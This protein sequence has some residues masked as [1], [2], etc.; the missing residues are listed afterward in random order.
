[1][2]DLQSLLTTAPATVNQ[3]WF[4][5]LA[6]T[7]LH[8]AVLVVGGEAHRLLEIEFYYHGEGHEDPFAHC[9]PFQK[10]S[11]LWY[12]HRE[13]GE[14]RGGSFKGVDISFGPEGMFGGILIR[15]ILKPDGDMVNGCSLCVDHMLAT[16]NHPKIASLDGEIAGR[17]VWDTSSPLHLSL[18]DAADSSQPIWST[19]R[20]GLTLKRMYQNPTMP[21]FIMSDYRFLTQPTIPKGKVHT[22]VAM[23]KQGM[24]TDDIRA[25]TRSPRKSIDRYREQFEQGQQLESFNSFRGKALKV[26]DLCLIHGVWHET[27]GSSS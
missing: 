1:M 12:F 16:T 23:L 24:S 15:T 10:T 19:A 5:S 13:G 27:Y 7:L 9:D 3:A 21:D 14:Y 26:D 6:E 17:S 25:L 4:A 11:G 20:V 2:E 8:Q 22:V 18:L